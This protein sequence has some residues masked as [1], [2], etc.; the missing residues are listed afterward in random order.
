MAAALAG[1]SRALELLLAGG[2]SVESKELSFGCTAL[3]FACMSGNEDVVGM[4]LSHGATVDCADTSGRT[5]LMVA[6]ATGKIR[7]VE[8]LLRNGGDVNIRNRFGA[9]ALDLADRNGNIGVAALLLANGAAFLEPDP[10]VA[11]TA[12]V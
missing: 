9:T 7:I 2:A 5:P 8:I 12:L 4:I 1:R 10:T 11:V 3:M 6:A